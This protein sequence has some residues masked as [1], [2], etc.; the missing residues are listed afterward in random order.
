MIEYAFRA[1][2][3]A[4]NERRM[5]IGIGYNVSLIAFDSAR[6]CWAFD[7]EEVD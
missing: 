6:N 7:V 2:G 3:R 5:M 4:R 1:E